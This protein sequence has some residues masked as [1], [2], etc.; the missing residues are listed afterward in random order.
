[1]IVQ[2]L[3]CGLQLSFGVLV[4]PTQK[5]YNLHRAEDAGE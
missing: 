2:V 5:K 1:M 3:N 4:G